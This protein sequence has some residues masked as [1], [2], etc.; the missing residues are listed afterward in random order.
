MS[1]YIEFDPTIHSLQEVLTPNSWNWLKTQYESVWRWQ[2]G[3]ES[4]PK[5][6]ENDW[7][8]IWACI[9]LAYEILHKYPQLATQINITYLTNI[10]LIHDAGE[11]LTGDTPVL[12]ERHGSMY[13][14]FSEWL[15][16]LISVLPSLEF[17]PQFEESLT[18]TKLIM[19][20]NN[21]NNPSICLDSLDSN[22]A[23]AIFVDV[24]QGSLTA[25]EQLYDPTD[26][27]HRQKVQEKSIP[28]FLTA[29]QRLI[30]SFGNQPQVLEEII[31]LCNQYFHQIFDQ[32]QPELAM[33]MKH[34]R[35]NG[36]RF[37]PIWELATQLNLPQVAATD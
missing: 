34:D 14:E 22:V 9:R 3:D 7:Q 13:K 33:A 29:V 27:G 30:I 35:Q 36:N 32:Y 16:F 1:D 12:H 37:A 25:K 11:I 5:I 26:T 8:H 2:H 15:G 4:F 24:C 18:K 31:K 20:F 28:R 6:E 21:F 17:A 10:F 19:L 23:L